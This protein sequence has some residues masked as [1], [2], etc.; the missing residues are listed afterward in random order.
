[1]VERK[2]W[3][4]LKR[5]T[6]VCI[7]YST[8]KTKEAACIWYYG[9]LFPGVRMRKETPQGRIQDFKLGGAHLKNFL[10]Y[11]VWKIT[12]L[13]QK[14]LFFPIAKGGANIFG[15]F[16]VKNH[17]FTPQNHYFFHIFE[18]A[19][20]PV[21]SNTGSFFCFNSNLSNLYNKS[22]VEKIN[23]MTLNP[24]TTLKMIYLL[25]YHQ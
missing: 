17:D 9:F 15:V 24:T 4:C 2:V 22:D 18:S 6:V 12:I 16:R 23:G 11:F 25:K 19:P 7:K 10:G 1:M 20:A 13:R 21:I 5:K 14:I 8:I 3:D